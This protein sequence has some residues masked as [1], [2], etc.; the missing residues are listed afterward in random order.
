MGCRRSSSKRVVYADTSDRTRKK[1]QNTAKQPNI[2]PKAT[3]E[4]RTATPKVKK[5]E[6]IKITAEINKMERKISD[7][8]GQWN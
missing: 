8:G 1:K 4:R 7:R 6:V 5:K 2:V 3:W